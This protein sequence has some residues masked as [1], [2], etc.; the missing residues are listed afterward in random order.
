MSQTQSRTIAW[1]RKA[2]EIFY[3]FVDITDRRHIFL[4]SSGIAFNLLLCTIPLVILVLSI[5]SGI[6]DETQTKSTVQQFLVNF[7]PRNTQASAAIGEVL[8]ELGSVF[9]YG[10]LAGW[11]AGVALLWL[12]STLFSSLRTGLNA[13][14]HITTPK[15]FVL[16]KLKDMLMTIIAAVVILVVTL[17]SP[18]LTL[19][20]QFWVGAIPEQSAG[21]IFG[22]TVRVASLIST[23]IAFLLLY[24]LVPNKRLPWPIVFMSTGIAVG[25]WEVARVVFSWYVNGAANF[26]KFY[27]GYVALASFALWLY[28]SAFVF[29]L[30]AELGQYIHK[31][32]TKHT[33]PE[34]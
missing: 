21:M 9:S 32:R 10:T 34:V 20:E 14:F 11:I 2:W 12:S 28:Y 27:G 5:V 24:K 3:A 23:A 33:V 29:L 13:I 19:V 1:L 8:K 4:L 7:L 26:S 16:Y 15:F 17:L 6:I 25:L 18:L 22:L 31:L 30:S